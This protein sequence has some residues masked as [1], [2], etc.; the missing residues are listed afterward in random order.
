MQSTNYSTL[1][2]LNYS[3]S[4]E[5]FHF[6]PEMQ[7]MLI[8]KITEYDDTL[9][10]FFEKA[11]SSIDYLQDISPTIMNEIIFQ[12]IPQHYEKGQVIFETDNEADAVF[13][14][15]NGMVEIYTTMEGEVD[16]IIERLYRGSVINHKSFLL[17]D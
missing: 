16:F 9:K 4:Q 14:I 3:K 11:L 15:Q 5:M 12:F 6:F 8:E 10:F 1:G 13:I 7:N 2:A 17:R